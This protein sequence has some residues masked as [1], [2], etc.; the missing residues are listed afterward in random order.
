MVGI[1]RLPGACGEVVGLGMVE[2]DEKACAL[3]YLIKDA[4]INLIFDVATDI[5]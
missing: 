5:T 4:P 1:N 2:Y 3:Y